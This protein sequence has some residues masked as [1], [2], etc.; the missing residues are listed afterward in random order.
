MHPAYFL[1]PGGQTS[2]DCLFAFPGRLD[3]LL[4]LHHF[5]CL[6][7]HALVCVYAPIGFP[8]YFAGVLVLEMGSGCMNQYW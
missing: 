8:I 5:W 1:L 4:I 6:V 3:N 7:G 2:Y